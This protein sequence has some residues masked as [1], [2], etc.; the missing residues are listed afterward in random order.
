[1]QRSLLSLFIIFIFSFQNTFATDYYWVGGSG[2][3][4]DYGQHWAKTAGG[5][6]FHTQVP[7]P[8]DNIFFNDN[9]LS[10]RTIVNLDQTIE[11][12][13]DISVT[14]TIDTLLFNSSAANPKLSIYGST[15]LSPKLKVSTNIKF[16]FEAS[17]G[18]QTFNQNRAILPC[19][20][21]FNNSGSWQITDSMNVFYIEIL[22]MFLVVL[23]SLRP[24]HARPDLV[25]GH[26]HPAPPQPPRPPNR[27]LFF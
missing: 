18:S 24:L 19:S 2:N 1:M 22:L 11:S 27:I 14:I 15:L 12:C 5:N 16:Y 4:T 26:L 21:I 10:G 13:K 25:F 17:S 23:D 20:L 8:L 6:V 7:G 9:S 3:W